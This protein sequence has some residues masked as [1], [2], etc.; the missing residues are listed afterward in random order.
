MENVSLNIEDLTNVGC[1]YYEV[2]EF[3][4]LAGS[5]DSL[6]IFQQNIRSFNVN[7]DTL[8][9]FLDSLSQKVDILVHT[10]TWFAEGLCCNIEGYKAFHTFG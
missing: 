10:E 6:I 3:N 8:S 9:C 1:L 5:H 2:S 4:R 7:F